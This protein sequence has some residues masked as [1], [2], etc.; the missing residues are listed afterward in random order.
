MFDMGVGLVY[1]VSNERRRYSASIAGGF[2]CAACA[3][4]ESGSWW[5]DTV[6]GESGVWRVAAIGHCLAEAVSRAGLRGITFPAAGSATAVI[7]A[8]GTWCRL[9]MCSR[10]IIPDPMIP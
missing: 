5:N 3:G 9:H 10:P 4:D 8:P 6:G 1:T 7:S 2:G